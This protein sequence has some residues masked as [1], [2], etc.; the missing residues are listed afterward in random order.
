MTR[1]SDETF[2]LGQQVQVVL[3]NDG[4]V[5]PPSIAIGSV[6]KH[7]GHYVTVVIVG[8]RGLAIVPAE[9]VFMCP[10]QATRW[11]FKRKLHG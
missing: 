5:N 9:H 6:V 1:E 10:E 11:V 2:K 8:T 3:W 4:S 7:L